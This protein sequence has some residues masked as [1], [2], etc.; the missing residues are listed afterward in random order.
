MLEV[1]KVFSTEADTETTTEGGV[2]SVF[3]VGF[4]V[5]FFVGED[6]A[7]VGEAIG[8]EGLKESFDDQVE[9]KAVVEVEEGPAHTD[10]SEDRESLAS[11]GATCSTRRWVGEGGTFCIGGV[12][13]SC[14]D[15]V[16][17][18]CRAEATVE[19][20]GGGDLSTK[21]EG[22]HHTA[23]IHERAV[24]DTGQESEQANVSGK[25]D[26]F[27]DGLCGLVAFFEGVV[28]WFI[29]VFF[30]STCDL[31][32]HQSQHKEEDE[33]ASDS[34]ERMLQRS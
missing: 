15:G 3:V 26:T 1:E 19:F 9:H 30:G 33:E 16:V 23:T 21:A 17:K 5:L 4:E 22:E 25:K 27:G 32:D 10:A 20:D 31:R 13:I 8:W 14:T 11:K 29:D 34:H 18:K 7:F 24:T 12:W 2:E 28:E 6:G